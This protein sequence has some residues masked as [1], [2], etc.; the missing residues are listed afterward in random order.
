[1]EQEIDQMMKFPK[2]NSQNKVTKQRSKNIS[3]LASKYSK[4]SHGISGGVSALGSNRDKLLDNPNNLTSISDATT[5]PSP[6]PPHFI[7]MTPGEALNKY[8]DELTMFEKTEL[9]QFE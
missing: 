3:A 9:S 4:K 8:G 6:N 2:S 1:M 7:G 5:N